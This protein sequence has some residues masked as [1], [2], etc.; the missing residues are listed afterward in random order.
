MQPAGH[1]IHAA[2]QRVH[3]ERERWCADEPHQVAGADAL[4]GQVVQDDRVAV[5]MVN[6][7]VKVANALPAVQ[8]HRQHPVRACTIGQQPFYGIRHGPRCIGKACM[9][10]LGMTRHTRGVD[11]HGG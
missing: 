7:D 5:H 1:G 2:G 10:P 9:N 3:K 8:V 11:G 4:G 6:W